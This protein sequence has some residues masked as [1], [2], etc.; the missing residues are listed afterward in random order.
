LGWNFG[1][2]EAKK[3]TLSGSLH[4][5]VD[6]A[7][8]KHGAM[9]VFEAAAGGEFGDLTPLRKLGLTV[10]TLDDAEQISFAAHQ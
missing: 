3:P 10:E 8:Q 6:E 1:W 9:K 4:M 2:N 5:A 7:I